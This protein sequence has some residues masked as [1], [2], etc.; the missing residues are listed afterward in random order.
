MPGRPAGIEAYQRLSRSNCH[1]RFRSF[2]ARLHTKRWKAGTWHALHTFK[3]AGRV[4]Q[5]CVKLQSVVWVC[6]SASLAG[7]KARQGNLTTRFPVV[8][9]TNRPWRKQLIMHT[10][11]LRPIARWL[12]ERLEKMKTCQCIMTSGFLQASLQFAAVYDH[13]PLDPKVTLG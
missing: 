13:E 12:P 6:T 7:Y 5:V 10:H 4:V 2:P 11:M 9:N 1:Q 3:C 8:W